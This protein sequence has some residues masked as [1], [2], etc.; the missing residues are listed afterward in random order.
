MMH[1]RALQWILVLLLIPSV[2][3]C[4]G[5]TKSHPKKNTFILDVERNASETN[6]V[7]KSFLKIKGFRMAPQYEGKGFVYRI[8]AL[9]FESDFYNQ[10][11]ISPSVLLAEETREWISQAGIF[12]RVLAPD[13]RLD[14]KY[15]LEGEVQALYGDY[16]E[17]DVPKAVLGIAMTLIR[18]EKHS[19]RPV[20]QKTYQSAFRLDKNTPESLVKGWNQGLH[21]ILTR[22]EEDLRASPNLAE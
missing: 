7:L 5:L 9:R 18:Y 12:E 2:T 14:A 20:F 17:K 11:F 15:V 21:E 8:G 10:F 16:I 6:I 22:F 3:G 1:P 19:P 4:T 13:S